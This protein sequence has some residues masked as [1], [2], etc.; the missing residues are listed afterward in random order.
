MKTRNFLLVSLTLGVALLAVPARAK[1]DALPAACGA[2][3]TQYKVSH[4]RPDAPPTAPAGQALVVLIQKPTG[5][6][7]SSEPILRLAV[8]GTWVGAVK[9]RSYIA[10]PVS[11]GSHKLCV[12]RQSSFDD[13]KANLSTAPLNAQAG[14][15]YYYEFTLNHES[16]GFAGR[17][18]GGAGG[19]ASAPGTGSTPDMTAK[20]NDTIDT[21]TF[22][23]LKEDAAPT[24]MQRMKTSVWTQK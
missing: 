12:S 3:T 2:D 4:I 5:E 21:V 24:H 19:S 13:E 1:A 7:F 6:E 9:G 18:N 17:A 10:I 22:T 11:P 20:R 8:D 14:A 15:V 23:Q 16:V